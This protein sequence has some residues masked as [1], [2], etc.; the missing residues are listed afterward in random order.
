MF[1]GIVQAIGKVSSVAPQGAGRRLVIDLAGWTPAV[2][3]RHGDSI[4]VSGVCLTVVKFDDHSLAFDVIHETLQRSS[5]GRLKQGDAVNLEPSL[6]LQT[7][8][9][10]HFVQGHVDGVGEVV[11]IQSGDDWR[12][13]IKPPAGVMDYIAAKGAIT[14]EGVSLTV[15]S[16]THD[17]FEIALIPA[18]LQLTTLASL[19][20]GDPVNLETD[21]VARQIVHYLQ[22]RSTGGSVS[23][24]ALR[25]AGFVD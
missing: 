24:S 5:L 25:E 12:A 21:I 13:R 20:S 17:D 8:M 2:G 23:M 22:R 4:C 11:S 15:A 10:G 1:T 3:V 7:P 19:K 14:V 6:T 16:V 18:T 9:G